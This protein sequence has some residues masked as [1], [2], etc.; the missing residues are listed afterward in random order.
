MYIHMGRRTRKRK[1]R[2]TRRNKVGGVG[3]KKPIS[4][5]GVQPAYWHALEEETG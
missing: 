3:K 4:R 5:Y 1:K 2:Q